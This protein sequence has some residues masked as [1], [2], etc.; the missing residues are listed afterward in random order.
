MAVI[1]E[2]ID[3]HTGSFDADAQGE[4]VRRFQVEGVHPNG[5]TLATAVSLGLPGANTPHPADPSLI[6]D[7]Y[8][9]ERF[10][11]TNDS[12]AVAVYTTNK[13]GRLRPPEQ[14]QT[15]GFL[16]WSARPQAVETLVPY[17]RRKRYADA[18]NP[19]T[20]FEAW[21]VQHLRL[22]EHRQMWTL[23]VGVTFATQV[24]A[25]NGIAN[26]MKQQ[27]VIHNIGGNSL[28]YSCQ[29]MEQAPNSLDWSFVHEWEGDFGTKAIPAPTVDTANFSM[30][31]TL[32]GAYT[33]LCRFPFYRLVA[34]PATN[35]R[36]TPP[37]FSSVLPYTFNDLGYLTLPG[38]PGAL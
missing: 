14:P 21:E 26:C 32:T 18:A 8:D 9:V 4:R 25:R 35:P 17:G 11:E 36:T 28:R 1:R 3:T 13:W 24:D 29:S 38:V 27:N 37:I 10:G 31:P 5:I 12:L 23:R 7:R 33:G 34:Y 19:S 22:I 6:L 2:L 16:S 20:F 15:A 30:P